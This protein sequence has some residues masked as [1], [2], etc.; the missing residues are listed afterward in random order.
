[1]EKPDKLHTHQRE[2]IPRIHN[3][4]ILG[5]G[6]GT[7]KT[8]TSLTYFVEVICGGDQHREKPMETPKDLVVI[9]TAKVRGTR[10]WQDTAADLGLFEDPEFSYSRK[11][12]IVDSWNNLGKYVEMKDAFF[13]FD[14]QRVVGSGAWVKN[15]LKVARNN[16]W[17]L[18]SATPADSW[19][20][21]VPVFI[22]NGF[23]R[24]RTHFIDDH[25]VY[26]FHGKYRKIR[27]FYGVRHLE[28]LRAQILVDMPY[29]RH[30]T[31][32]I[33]EVP[34]EY[35]VEKF[36]RVWKARWNVYDDC[37]I[38]D[39]AEMYRLGRKVVNE[40]GR[41]QSKIEEL[42]AKHPR[43]IVFYNFDYE[44][45]AL[46]EMSERINKALVGSIMNAHVVGTKP[47]KHSVYIGRGSRWGNPFK[48][49][50][51]GTREEVIEKYR[52]YIRADDELMI[53]LRELVGRSLVCWCAPQD[54][55]GRILQELVM[56]KF[57][58][59]TAEL[60]GHKHEDVPE[61][62][63]WLYLVQY[64]AGAEGWNC[65]ETD[66]IAYHSLTYSHKQYEQSLGRIDRL[67]TPF[68]DLHYYVLKSDSK[69]DKQIWRALSNK[70][71]FH[72]GRNLKF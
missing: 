59:K 71:N 43:L 20:D 67:N 66:A 24:N 28:R 3:G 29:D 7:G 51:D 68:T 10:N 56:E 8:I 60:N 42:L 5:G 63:R 16:Q 65:V 35:D 32:H 2:V 64:T 61:D 46:R 21:Y 12:L 44:L 53:G 58:V 9:T 72:E 18:L 31:R 25:V 36:N 11:R 27:G 23:Y 1:M 26:S 49:G 48:I 15:F 40:D 45:F 33:H 62:E 19:M 17:I 52:E 34:V 22:A 41:R 38:V 47:N 69:V 6:V 55:H 14:E 39:V 37:P 57:G 70:K 30:T 13:I 50:E 4:C 54:C